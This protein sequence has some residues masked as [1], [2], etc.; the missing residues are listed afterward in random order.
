MLGYDNLAGE[1]RRRPHWSLALH[2]PEAQDRQYESYRPQQR[3][4]H[5]QDESYRSQYKTH[6][7]CDSFNFLAVTAAPARAVPNMAASARANLARYF[8]F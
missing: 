1:Y 6:L 8:F 2:G 4:H 3:S 5:Q 7:V